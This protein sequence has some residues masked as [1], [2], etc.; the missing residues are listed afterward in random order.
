MKINTWPL[1]ILLI[2]GS[3]GCRTANAGKTGT[4]EAE[5]LDVA[6]KIPGRVVEVKVREGDR[7]RRGDPLV[8]LQSDDIA[9]KVEQ[10]RSGLEA[11]RAQLAMAEHGARPQEKEMA[12]RQFNIA[13]DNLDIVE[14]THQRILKVYGDGGV[15]AQEKDLSEAR[16]RVAR[17]QYEQ[18]RSALD[19]VLSGARA[20]QIDMLKAQ[21]RGME[22]KLREAASYQAETVLSAPQDAEVKGI[23]VQ[24]GEV[25]TPGFAAVTLLDSAVYVILNLRESEF[26]ALKIGDR[27]QG[28]VP[29]LNRSVPLEVYAIAPMADFAKYEATQE[30]GSWDVRTFEVRLRP[31]APVA[32]LR[33]GMTVRFP[34]ETK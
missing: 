26:Q 11:A 27:R 5:E 13:K 17:E 29:A 19:L 4:A 7:V 33:P 16:Y 30:K 31:L 24:P 10:A 23:N 25:V 2:V 20:E 12:R 3:L 9:A 28:T 22:E 32:G 1:V 14:K 18:A 15:S 8:V 21:V 6:A 34:W